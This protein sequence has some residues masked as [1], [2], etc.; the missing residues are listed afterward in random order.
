MHR[1]S[2]QG[3]MVVTKYML[4]KMFGRKL[5][6]KLLLDQRVCLWTSEIKMHRLKKLEDA[7]SRENAEDISNLRSILRNC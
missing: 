3:G 2:V 1:P 7:I 5:Q 4:R 6:H